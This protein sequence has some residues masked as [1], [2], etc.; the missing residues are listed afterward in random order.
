MRKAILRCFSIYRVR[1]FLK[2]AGFLDIYVQS[3]S[4]HFRF[5][6]MFTI[7]LNMFIRITKRRLNRQS[8]P[9]FDHGHIKV[10]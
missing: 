3:A 4:A 2:Y 9:A 1:P 8:Q 5:S 6:Q 10:A 7:A